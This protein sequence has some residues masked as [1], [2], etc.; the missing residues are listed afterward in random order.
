MIAH[1]VSFFLL[2]LMLLPAYTS[3]LLSPAP[4]F[5]Q[6]TSTLSD[7]N[8]VNPNS[9]GFRIVVCDGPT[10]PASQPQLLAARNS[11]LGRPYVACDFN[12]MMKQVQHVIN[13][14]VVVG[15]LAAILGFV[16]AG[17][18]YMTGAEKN[19]SK[20]KSIFPKVGGGFIIMLSA[21]FIVYQLLVWFTGEN[22]GFTTLLGK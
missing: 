9:P 11:E 13:L 14:A 5:A 10:I 4:V 15:V 1:A 18:L 6:R 8:Y 19:I 2:L 20:A 12:G 21:W 22:S 17:A 7:E 16:Y 3:F